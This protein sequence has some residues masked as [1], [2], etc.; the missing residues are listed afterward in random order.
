MLSACLSSPLGKVMKGF[1]GHTSV[2]DS[3]YRLEGSSLLSQRSSSLFFLP[4]QLFKEGV[5]PYSFKLAQLNKSTWHVRFSL[6]AEQGRSMHQ[7]FQDHFQMIWISYWRKD[8]HG[9]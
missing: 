4:R 3:A 8:S 2:A 9:L 1:F 7:D 6:S 5:M